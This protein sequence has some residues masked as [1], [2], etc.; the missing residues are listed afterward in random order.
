LWPSYKSYYATVAPEALSRT[1]VFE[2]DDFV[3]RFLS[4]KNLIL[5]VSAVVW[6]RRALLQAMDDCEV[7]LRSYKM[8]G[9]WRLYLQALSGKGARVGYCSEALNTHRR[10]AGSVTH[11]LNAD[12]HVAEIAACHTFAGAA[13]D[14]SPEIKKSQSDYLREVRSQLGA[15]PDKHHALDATP[16]DNPPPGLLKRAS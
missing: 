6:R 3:Q 7:E 13:F 5:N 4:V 1:G 2:A 15:T 9:D 14:L 16:A 12:Q 8:A 11:A 10:H